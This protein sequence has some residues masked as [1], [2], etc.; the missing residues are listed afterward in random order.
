M[1]RI[2]DGA[3]EKRFLLGSPEA[4][5]QVERVV[6]QAGQ[7]L[8][9][10]AKDAVDY[11]VADRV[12]ESFEQL[13]ELESIKP[14]DV[15]TMDTYLFK[16]LADFLRNPFMAMALVMVGI[17]CLLLE[18]KMPGIG[19]PGV[20][21]AVCFVLFFWSQ[22]HLAGQVIWLALLLFILGLLF[23]VIEV[24]LLPGM[25]V[26]GVS[27]AVLV[28][29]SLGLVTYGQLPRSSDQWLALGS[30]VGPFGLVFVGAI[31]AALVIANYLPH[32]PILNRMVHQPLE[33]TADGQP[34]DIH[35]DLSGLLGAIGVAATSLRPAG[36]AQ[37]GDQ[38]LD[39]VSQG[40]YI[41]P[42]TRLQVV[43]IEGNRIVVKDV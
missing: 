23:I 27:G 17:T 1:R 33:E 7:W 36:K 11:H 10:S 4:V 18:M 34:L 26:F 22:S 8:M 2:K 21:A 25:A 38:F 6:K 9:L 19:L 28:L 39:V 5:W 43:E 16:W 24:F 29:G 15:V 20:I 30:N 3:S 31:V 32:I 12:A 13:C 14:G 37:F 35:P 42:G 40:S 41:Q